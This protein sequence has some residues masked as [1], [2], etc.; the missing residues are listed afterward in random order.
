M[1]QTERNQAILRKYIPEAAVPMMAEWIVQFDFK[2]KIKRSRQSK[3]GDYRAPLPGTNHQITINHDLNPYAFLLT[4]VHEV[5]HLL[6]FER[7]GH[8]VKP[9]GE[10]WKT[11]F[12]DLMRPVMRLGVFPADVKAAIVSYMQNPGATSCSD[13]QLMRTLRRHDDEQ[14]QYIHLETLP[15]DTVFL[16]NGRRFRKG[17][18]RRTRYLCIELDTRRQYLFSALADVELDEP[19]EP[20]HRMAAHHIPQPQRVAAP[21]APPPPSPEPTPH[22][23]S[24]PAPAPLPAFQVKEERVPLAALPQDALFELGGIVYKKGNAVHVH[25]QCTIVVTGDLVRFSPAVLVRRVE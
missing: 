12:K 1:N 17:Q 5:A 25:L 13:L 15:D 19:Q 4:L 2:L 10:E 16:Y 3:Y 22:L 14:A 21:P 24:E 20:M 23:P 6:T 9:H 7:H 8:R 18:K 11:A